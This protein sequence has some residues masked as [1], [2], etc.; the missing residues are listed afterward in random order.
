MGVSNTNGTHL[1]LLMH[2]LYTHPKPDLWLSKRLPHSGW[3]N[4][5]QCGAKL[6][7]RYGE[8]AN[9]SPARFSVNTRRGRSP[10]CE[11][12]QI[13]HKVCKN[14]ETPEA[15]HRTSSTRSGARC[16]QGQLEISRREMTWPSA[17]GLPS[18][19]PEAGA[20]WLK[21]NSCGSLFLD[22]PYNRAPC[23]ITAD[24]AGW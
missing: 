7:S 1:W 8:M 22:C 4:M 15:P 19:G 10:P 23:W 21:P 9:K 17:C 18:F 5:P 14:S 13:A 2:P 11:L 12:P 20:A 16:V 3:R 24:L 6:P